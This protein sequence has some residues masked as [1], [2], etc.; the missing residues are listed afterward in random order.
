MMWVYHKLG[1]MIDWILCTR[2]ILKKYKNQRG[3][4]VF[5][6]I[7]IKKDNSLREILLSTFLNDCYLED[8]P[9]I[10]KPNTTM[11]PLKENQYIQIHISKKSNT[12]FFT[13]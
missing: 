6:G 7:L 9:H 2:G 1:I 4:I 13:R 12:N 5:V 8:Y 11:T 10:A 3:K